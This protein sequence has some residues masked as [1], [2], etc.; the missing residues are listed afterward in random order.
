MEESTKGYRE[1][2]HTADA[3]I[4]V[5]A[6]TIPELFV[7]SAL[8]MYHI[9]QVSLVHANDMA[10]KKTLQLHAGDGESL[11]IAFLDELLFVLEEERIVFRGITVEISGM[12]A[13]NSSLTGYPVQKQEREIKAVTYHNIKIKESAAGFAVDIVFDI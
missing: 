2:V 11:L 5:W 10:R 9:A 8:G 13:L 6:Q 4:H 1:F 12:T 3:G 7:Q